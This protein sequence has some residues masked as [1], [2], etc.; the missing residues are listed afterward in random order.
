MKYISH[1]FKIT[2]TEMSGDSK[3]SSAGL[4]GFMLPNRYMLTLFCSKLSILK[5]FLG[6]IKISVYIK[7]NWVQIIQNI[8]KVL[9]R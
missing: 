4:C 7:K 3:L 8:N 1:Y 9:P 6:I 2:A 5:K